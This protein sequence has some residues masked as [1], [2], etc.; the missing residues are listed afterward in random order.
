MESNQ[1]RFLNETVYCI[2]YSENP[3]LI[4]SNV[5]VIAVTHGIDRNAFQTVEKQDTILVFLFTAG[6]L[7]SESA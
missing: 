6:N 4:P 1:N 3:H 5:T 7:L 2:D